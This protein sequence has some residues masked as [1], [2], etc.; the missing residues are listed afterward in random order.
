MRRFEAIPFFS[1]L[2]CDLPVVAIFLH[3]SDV[4]VGECLDCNASRHRAWPAARTRHCVSA[5]QL[6]VYSWIPTLH[7]IIWIGA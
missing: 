6:L 4:H 7:N 5:C 2:S 3:C 1:S